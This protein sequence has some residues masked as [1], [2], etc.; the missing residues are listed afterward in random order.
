MMVLPR[1]NLCRRI[2]LA[3]FA[4]L[5]LAGGAYAQSCEALKAEYRTLGGGSGVARQE[6]G[7]LVGVYQQL[8]C[9]GGGFLFFGPP[10]AC[11]GIG[12]RLRSLQGVMASGGGE[13]VR[14]RKAQLRAEIAQAC[15]D[16]EHASAARGF[17]P[18]GGKRLV[19]VRA[20][21]GFYFPLANR[22]EDGDSESLCQALCPGSETTVFRM[23]EG[24]AIQEAVSSRGQ[25]Y[26]DLPN[27]LKYRTSVDKSCACK[28]EGQSWTEAL[29][30]AETMIA[31][32]GSDIVVDAKIA[33]K[34]SQA[35]NAKAVAANRK[36]VREEPIE[37]DIVVRPAS[38]A[39]ATPAS[40]TNEAAAAPLVSRVRVIGLTPAAAQAGAAEI[41]TGAVTSP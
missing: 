24:G 34:L 3:A 7:Q 29:A 40:T 5:G 27:A 23:P 35:V 14:V 38:T 12:A 1:R 32:R 18:R 16:G 28:G 8:N 25:A 10:A 20:C 22:P 9:G 21:D 2:A 39:A 31:R 11:R 19:C 15:G 33:A 4:C 36:P 41:Q 30:R 37:N 26:M 17:S 13:D 6:Y